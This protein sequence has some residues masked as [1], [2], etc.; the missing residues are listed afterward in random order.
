MPYVMRFPRPGRVPLKANYAKSNLTCERRNSSRRL[1]PK[2]CTGV[3]PANESGMPVVAT[4][5]PVLPHTQ[6]YLAPRTCMSLDCGSGG[7]V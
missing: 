3:K 2:H 5:T 4:A 6:E 1:C 7:D